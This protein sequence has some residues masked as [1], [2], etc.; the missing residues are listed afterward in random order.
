MKKAR[1]F[2]TTTSTTTTLT[3]RRRAFAAGSKSQVPD[4]KFQIPRNPK[5]IPTSRRTLGFGVLGFGLWIYLDNGSGR[6]W[7]LMILLVV[8]LPPSMWNGARVAY[9]L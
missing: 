8:P 7:N 9:V 1:G 6:T 3:L 4:P 5:K 2:V